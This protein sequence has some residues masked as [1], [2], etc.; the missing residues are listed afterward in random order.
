MKKTTIFAV[1]ALLVS[2]F[3]ASG[4][5]LAQEPSGDST[6]V[7]DG[8]VTPTLWTDNPK[9]T[10]L[11]YDFGYKDDSA[12]F[13]GSVDVTGDGAADI[14]WNSS[15]GYYLEWSSIGGFG[16]DAVIMKGGPNANV[17]EYDEGLGD[18][19]LSTPAA[20]HAIS[21][22]DFCYDYELEVSK[23]ANT[24]FTRTWDWDITK[25]PNGEY[26]M[27]IGED[28]DHTYTI[29]VDKLDY[30]DS[31]WAVEGTITICNNTPLDAEVEG[32]S[33]VVSDGI[34]ATVDC[35][36]EFPYTLLAGDTLT[37]SY[38]TSLPDGS[39]RTNTATVTTSGD[40]GG[41]EDTAAVD[42]SQATINEVYD[43]VYVTD[44]YGSSDTGDDLSFGPFSDDGSDEYTRNFDCPTDTSLYVNGVY[45]YTVNNTATIDETEDSD[46]ATVIVHCY[47][48][49]V[50]K[51]ANTSLTRTWTWTIDKSADQTD[52]T[53][54]TGEQF[55]V[56]YQ[57]TVDATYTDSDWAVEG[58]ITVY[59]YNTHAAM[60][61]S[62][63]D[64]ISDFGGTVSLTC[65]GSLT[66]PAGGSATCD[67]SADLP[68]GSNRTNTATATLNSIDFTGTADV[69]FGDPT[70]EVDE[71]ID[72]TDDR[73]GSLGLVCAGDA[74]K[75]FNYSLY[76][77]PYDACG[78]YQFTNIASFITND[79]G[80]TGGD[81]WTIDIDVPCEGCT[82]TPGYWKTHSQKGPAPYDDNWVNLGPDE[83]D[84]IFFLSGQSY[85][86]VLWTAP[87]GNAYY[88]LAH[89]YIAAKLNFLNGADPS[90]AQAAFDEATA[91]FNHYNPEEIADAKGKTGKE[92]R[93]QFID[94]AEILD[95]YNNG[96]IGPG[97]C[98][99]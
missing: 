46:D 53:L 19:G 40:V 47:A 87:R 69:I 3:T 25:D 18:S 11:G 21:H 89:A 97:H 26:W 27:F 70:T 54:A 35:G 71:C 60:T 66:V 10:H 81:S 51:D 24:S 78:T 86:E 58:T 37:C 75:T 83:E 17:Y 55:E 49:V 15:D 20:G 45:E 8:G 59:N 16:I 44:D 52:L 64:M 61:V 95:D 42:F 14:S 36:V 68:D 96:Y 4:L 92:L 65:S 94:L 32:V 88:I 84:T 99:E 2:L 93:A 85:Y 67:Y 91:L 80:T 57:A 73:Y 28:T 98:S 90:A 82:L 31:D 9:C 12:P 39:N 34:D 50:D 23:D 41:D 22:V 29:D 6:P 77:G 5:A 76:V 43:E 74:P 48:P 13:T 63:A 38:S 30:T 62:L 56:N 7:S 1:L 72:V 79:T 33:D